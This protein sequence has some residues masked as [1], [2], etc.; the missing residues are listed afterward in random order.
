MDL[1]EVEPEIGVQESM[2]E[3]KAKAHWNVHPDDSDFEME[4]EREML[5]E[6]YKL[7]ELGQP[8]KGVAVKGRVLAIHLLQ[9]NIKFTRLFWRAVAIQCKSREMWWSW[10]E[11]CKKA[12]VQVGKI[13]LT[14]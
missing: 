13:Y 4:L 6:D 5:K 3:E 14:F 10:T 2:E 9:Q 11:Q 7:A 12:G 8:V 1:P